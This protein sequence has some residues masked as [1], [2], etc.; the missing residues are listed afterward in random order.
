MKITLLVITAII[1]LSSNYAFSYDG[2]DSEK[3]T[4]VIGNK[5][6]QLDQTIPE[7]GI[8]F[9]MSNESRFKSVKLSGKWNIYDAKLKRFFLKNWVQTEA[10][11]DS[12]DVTSKM[13]I[14]EISDKY[15]IVVVQ[16]GNI[17]LPL[18]EGFVSGPLGGSELFFVNDTNGTTCR[19]IKVTGK[20][21]YEVVF[22]S[23]FT[24]CGVYHTTSKDV[25]IY[26][27][28]SE[29]YYKY[30]L[31]NLN[32]PPLYYGDYQAVLSGNS[33]SPGNKGPKRRSGEYKITSRV[34]NAR[35]E[36]VTNVDCEDGGYANAYHMKHD[37]NTIGYGSGGFSGARSGSFANIGIED[38]LHKACMGE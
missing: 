15:H 19:A 27:K 21:K 10:R 33:S 12:A 13:V 11:M 4:A 30:S 36:L 7:R 8:C 17:L 24:N 34:T 38:A 32:A 23:P 2:Y 20:H 28:S 26:N 22:T 6:V 29:E 37:Y 25:T 3:C 9:Y 1:T 35:G 16:S 14:V 5:T 31:A 18:K